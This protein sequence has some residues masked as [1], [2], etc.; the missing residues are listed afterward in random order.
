MDR[1]IL[2]QF[3]LLKVINGGA[4]NPF[5]TNTSEVVAVVEQLLQASGSWIKHLPAGG[6]G[7]G[8][9]VPTG[10]LIIQMESTSPILD[11]YA[12]GGG[13][14]GYE[15][16]PWCKVE[17]VELVVEVNGQPWKVVLELLEQLTLVVEAVVDNQPTTGGAGGS[18]VV[19]IR[20]KF[21]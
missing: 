16:Q 6:G 19:I 9:G 21:Q 8:A 7:N 12:G 2:L 10:V 3:L 20:Y 4:G 13:G 1:K 18:G 14:G 17:V 15:W 5:R 11:A